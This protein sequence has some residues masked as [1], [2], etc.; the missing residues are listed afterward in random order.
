VKHSLLVIGALAL[1]GSGLLALS[2]RNPERHAAE[3]RQLSSQWKMTDEAPMLSQQRQGVSKSVW[4]GEG[5]SRRQMLM[6][7]DTGELQ[8][9]RGRLMEELKGVHAQWQERFVGD[10]LQLIEELNADRATYD[11]ARN[12]LLTRTMTLSRWQANGHRIEA[13]DQ[14]RTALMNADA[15]SAVIHIGAPP[16][17]EAEALKAKI[18][19][20][21][22]LEPPR[23][24]S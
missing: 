15:E 11:Y 3:Y 8:V 6:Q 24:E 10:E 17:L 7:A 14:T 23:S 5:E 12:N 2:L 13:K 16:R 9:K 4:F 18:F 20:P 22:K 19:Q 1:L 21:P